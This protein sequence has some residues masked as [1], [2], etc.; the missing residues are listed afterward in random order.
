MPSFDD[1]TDTNHRDA[2]FSASERSIAMERKAEH[3]FKKGDQ[4]TVFNQTLGGR[5]IIE[6]TAKIRSRLSHDHT[7][8]VQ[9]D[10]DPN[11]ETF[12]RRVEPGP[13]Q[14]DPNAF[15]AACLLGT[16]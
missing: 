10:G 4:V 2:E 11:A 1:M 14:D 8:R 9:F 6:G 3:A 15:V 7:Y 16:A 12:E 5:L 13:S